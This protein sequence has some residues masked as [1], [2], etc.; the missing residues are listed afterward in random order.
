[1]LY[2]VSLLFL[3]FVAS[4]GSAQESIDLLT[5]SGRYGIPQKVE[6]GFHGKATETGALVNLKV[7]VVISEATI[8]YNELSYT[9]F[10]VAFSDPQADGIAA[11]IAL[12]GFIL[13]TG[14][15]QKIDD[16]RKIHILAA[17][18]FMS[19]LHGST[20]ECWQIG[21]V[22]L[23]EKRFHDR[24]L[25]RFGA[26]YNQ[27]FFGPFMVP[28]VYVEWR[29]GKK[30]SLSGLLPIYGKLNYHASERLTLGLSEFGL[31]TSY[32]LGVPEYR[33]DYIERKSIDI[34]LFARYKLF[35][36]FHLEGRAGYA[37]S[38]EYG[39]YG[40]DDKVDFR[41]SILTFGDN[42]TRKNVLF[43]SGPIFNL[44][45]VYN[46]PLDENQ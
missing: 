5:L 38:R 41:V 25:M 4:A 40:K 24:L 32:R 39:Q 7:P 21:A 15:V 36:N 12:D 11:P 37:M 29:F 22:G 16:T 26:L 13:Q 20:G 31:I 17:P 2:K 42:R 27:E 6:E 18:R 8:W 44:R 19:D 1:L 28:L 35:G 46:L 33:G 10:H 45:L 43:N 9:N 34:T 23:F 14:L 30:W 3:L